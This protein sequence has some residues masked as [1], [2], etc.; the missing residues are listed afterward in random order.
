[1]K[2]SNSDI[3]QLKEKADILQVFGHYG[4]TLKKA[5]RHHQCCC[6]VHQEKTPSCVVDADK[7]SWH[8]Y[9]CGKGGD[10][11]DL[12]RE[13]RGLGFSDAVKELASIANFELT[14]PEDIDPKEQERANNRRAFIEMNKAAMG[15]FKDQLQQNPAAKEYVESRWSKEAIERFDIGYA[16]DSWDDLWSH[17]RKLGFN[18]EKM[19]VSSLFALSKNEKPYSYFRGRVMMPVYNITNEVIGFCGREFPHKEPN[20]GEKAAPKYLNTRND[21]TLYWKSKVFYGINFAAREIRA[22]NNAVIVEGNPDVIHMHDIGVSNVIAACGGELSNDQIAMLK[23]MCMSVTLLYDGDTAGQHDIERNGRKLL[24]AGMA[25]YAATIPSGP[26]GE[27]QDPDTFF[28]SKEHFDQFIKA[29]KKHWILWYAKYK[30]DYYNDPTEISRFMVE[31][32]ELLL[33]MGDAEALLYIN[34]LAE[35]IGDKT[36]WTAALNEAKHVAQGGIDTKEKFGITDLQDS[37]LHRYGFIE[38]HNQYFV[39]KG[40]GDGAPAKVSN[41]VLKP[42]F[43]IASSVNSKRIFTMSN[44]WGYTIDLEITQKDLGSRATFR[45]AVASRGNFL[46]TG[47]DEDLDKILAYIYDN[48]KTCNEITQLGWQPNGQFWAWSNGITL[49]NGQFIPVDEQGTVQYDNQ[50]YYLPALSSTTADDKEFYTFERK[51]VHHGSEADM[52]VWAN[53]FIAAFGKNAI[54]GISYAFSAL[55]RDVI[56]SR[57]RSFPILNCFGMPASGKTQFAIALLKLLGDAVEGPNINS[58]T[59]AA[60]GDHLGKVHNGFVHIDE[61]KNNIEIEKLELLKG[62]YESRGRMKMDMDRD[63]KRMQTPIDCA[64]ILTGQEMTTADNALFSRLVYLTFEK[65]GKDA[66]TMET[67]EDFEHYESQSLTPITNLVI[68]QRQTVE[69]HFAEGY[70]KAKEDL[71]AAIAEDSVEGRIFESYASILG[72]MNVLL[73]VSRLPLPFSYA[74]LVPLFASI[75]RR[76]D[77]SVSDTNEVSDFWFTL[78]SMM[79]DRKIEIGLDYRIRRKQTH[80]KVEVGSRRDR[81]KIEI[82]GPKDIIDINN[83]RIYDVFATFKKKAGKKTIPEDTLRYYLTSSEAFLGEHQA[84]YVLPESVE[85]RKSLSD[86][87]RNQQRSYAFDY[88]MIVEKYGINLEVEYIMVKNEEKIA[89]NNNNQQ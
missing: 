52:L 18:V 67:F 32:C 12:I 84:D 19:V 20:P 73:T 82:P 39:F 15:W 42:L 33:L 1:M 54:V 29:E 88:G 55:F 30:K 22:Q 78:Q 31:V 81:K 27:K 86:Y 72:M 8:C 44:E 71:R 13:Y 7:G 43:Q 21:N 69:D 9:G 28:E 53:K 3:Q 59:K 57:F 62:A 11:I 65:P 80:I 56:V 85:D 16:P 79:F 4:I 10:A 48:M 76:Q 50:W 38:D 45:T 60:L 46:F 14:N 64:L 40:R 35:I 17:L 5:G 2:I 75:M 66:A 89:Y 34:D 24:E 41:F 37:T 26:N 47:K 63:K 70:K 87:G 36:T 23:K 51:F 58:L 49:K 68:A 74:E 83:S 6:P 25:P 61:Y 77:A